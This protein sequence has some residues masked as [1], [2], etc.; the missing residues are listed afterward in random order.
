MTIPYAAQLSD[1][2]A[3]ARHTLKDHLG[4]EAW[5][6]PFASAEAGYR[7]KAKLVVSGTPRQPLLG[8]LGPDRR[9]VDLVDCG[10][11]EPALAVALEPLRAFIAELRLLPYDVAKARGELKNLLVTVNPEGE[12]AVRFVLRSEQQLPRI[13]DALADLQAILPQVRVVTANLLPEH[14]AL[15]DGPTEIGL[16]EQTALPMRVND[17]TLRLRARSFFQTNTTV[18]AGLY[19]QAREWLAGD[20]GDLEDLYCGVG[21]FAL[22]L[23]S[24]ARTVTG[25]ESTTEAVDCARAAAADLAERGEARFIV[26]DA[27]AYTPGGEAEVIVVNPPRRGLGPALAATLESGGARRVLYS[28]CNPVTLAADLTAMPSLRPIRAR[29]FDMFPQTGHAEVLVDLQRR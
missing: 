17:V 29:L 1:K 3:A 4:A 24:P 15:L 18:A 12:L 23:L 25:I 5:H 28:S 14:V 6:E 20:D 19:R 21:G 13:R 10:L 8:I 22:H 11:Y 7:N 16:T 9:G 27:T 26:A 2:D